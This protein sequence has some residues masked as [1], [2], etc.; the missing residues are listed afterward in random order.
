MP[1]NECTTSLMELGFAVGNMAGAAV[2]D[3][4]DYKQIGDILEAWQCRK[5]GD[6][7]KLLL[8]FDGLVTLAQEEC[9]A[10]E[11]P[12]I[13][14][15][16]VWQ[17]FNSLVKEVHDVPLEGHI[18]RGP[19]PPKVKGPKGIGR[20]KRGSV[21]TYAPPAPPAPPKPSGENGQTE[22]QLSL[23]GRYTGP[24]RGMGYGDEERRK[25]WYPARA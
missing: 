5:T 21:P 3:E 18:L 20:A 8:E 11:C 15:V 7:G 4:N 22:G 13:R 6:T 24:S 23:S 19:I 9:K 1:S 17:L 10:G 16:H 25:R 14:C 2:C 12:A